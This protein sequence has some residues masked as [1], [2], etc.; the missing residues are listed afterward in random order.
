MSDRNLLLQ[1]NLLTHSRAMKKVRLHLIDVELD[2]YRM[3]AFRKAL[4]GETNGAFCNNFMA[5]ITALVGED[6]TQTEE[7][8]NQALDATMKEFP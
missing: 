6:D 1:E 8:F 7:Q 5:G 4:C 3:R 2:A